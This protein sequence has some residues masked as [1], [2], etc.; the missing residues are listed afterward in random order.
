[1]AFV[2]L[3]AVLALAYPNVSGPLSLILLVGVPVVWGLS[4]LVHHYPA[5]TSDSVFL[6]VFWTV[7]AVTIGF[8]LAF[9]RDPKTNRLCLRR[10]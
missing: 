7:I 10:P 9:R 3:L 8:N 4:L 1:M 2:F 5:M 6:W